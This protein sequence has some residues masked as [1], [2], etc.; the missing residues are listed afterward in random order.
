[1]LIVVAYLILL[2]LVSSFAG[3]I[4]PLLKFE[5]GS[6]E[7][8]SRDSDSIGQGIYRDVLI[9]LS[10]QKVNG[11]SLVREYGGIP[12][13][14]KGDIITAKVKKDTIS[15]LAQD[16]RVLFVSASK[17]VKYH[18]D[19]VSAATGLFKLKEGNS[20]RFTGKGVI[21]GIVDSGIDYRH[22]AFEN[23]ILYIYDLSSGEVCD[24]EKIKNL[25]CNQR[26]RIGHGTHV[27]G[28]AAGNG[29]AP[30][31][32]QTPY[33]GIAPEAEIIMVSLGVESG[34]E[35]D[36]VIKGIE[37]IKNKAKELDK[38]LVV[39]LS[40]GT[41]VGPHDGTD[42]F[43]QALRKFIDEGVIIVK[44]AGNSA[45][46][47]LHI[48]GNVAQ[49]EEKTY[50]FRMKENLNLIDIWYPG[51]DKLEVKVST[52]CGDTDFIREGSH[53]RYRGS[54]AQVEILSDDV[55]PLNGDKEILIG[56]LTSPQYLSYKWAIT[57]KGSLIKKGG[58]HAWGTASEFDDG[59]NNYSVSSDSTLKELIVVGSFSSKVIKEVN[60]YAKP[61]EISIFSGRGPTRECSAGCRSVIKPDL[62]AP[63]DTVCSAYSS[64]APVRRKYIQ[65]CGFINYVPLSGTSM[66]APVVAGTVAL[67]LSKNPGLTPSQVKEILK[68]ATYSDSFVNGSLS[69]ASPSV[70][71][72]N[73]WGYGKLEI[74]KALEFTPSP[75]PPKEETPPP[76]EQAPEPTPQ[77]P[78]EQAPELVSSGGGGGCSTATSSYLLALLL[79]ALLL[80][81][82]RT[83]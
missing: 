9:K 41:D 49:G 22:P 83:L 20:R 62:A 21:V 24:K 79:L 38:P 11:E 14:Q 1:M 60:S 12:G 73:V 35:E 76:P 72:N 53:V 58:F 70:L 7:L 29:K 81:A 71:P 59:D 6:L 31:G 69:F 27:A 37:F 46:F 75:E 36:D 82:R 42:L 28:I 51:S 64:M 34:I 19:A 48:S 66:A 57:V 5:L 8:S 30:A 56:I 3:K 18:L 67:M 13:V 39:N 32:E 77:P 47:N 33:V 26:D 68:T 52:P 80:K 17:K 10:S 50:P 4:D 2:S 61:Y 44:S 16:D 43:S 74:A 45:Y 55:N 40:L 15:F 63:G 23:R 78:E 65:L 54:C 25:R